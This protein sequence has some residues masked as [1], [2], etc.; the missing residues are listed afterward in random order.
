MIPAQ[1]GIQHAHPH[2]E[3]AAARGRLEGCASCFET[4]PS[5]A[6]QHEG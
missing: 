2:P 3:E 1:A 5:G 4:R 6:P